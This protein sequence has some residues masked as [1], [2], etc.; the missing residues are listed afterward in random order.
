MIDEP[1]AITDWINAAD[2]LGPFAPLAS[3][4]EVLSDA[5][6]AARETQEWHYLAGVVA[7]RQM[8]AAHDRSALVEVCDALKARLA[9]DWKRNVRYAAEV[10]FDFSLA[11][12][13]LK[14][15]T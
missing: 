5:P 7:R 15:K 9:L 10:A 6:A 11:D 4:F 12:T 13:E 3:L 2:D 1:S 8:F 14:S